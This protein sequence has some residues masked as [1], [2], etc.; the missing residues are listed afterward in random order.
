MGEENGPVPTHLMDLLS[1]LGARRTWVS[2]QEAHCCLQGS[3]TP[4][5]PHE[6]SLQGRGNME[7]GRGETGPSPARRPSPHS[8]WPHS[9]PDGAG[10]HLAQSDRGRKRN[11]LK[12]F[13][14][15]F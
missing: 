11:I 6:D 13:K 8:L 7:N 1:R 3:E 5:G 9:R 12:H 14:G 10:A 4:T 15:T 2:H